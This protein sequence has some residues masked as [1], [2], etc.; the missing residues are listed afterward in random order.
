MKI[1]C[2]CVG[3]VVFGG[4][5]YVFGGLYGY[6]VVMLVECYD[7]RE[8]EWLIIIE[9]LYL[10]YGFCCVMIFVSKDLMVEV[11]FVKLKM[12]S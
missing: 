12:F 8:D 6:V 2:D 1:K 5:I 9:L 11:F 4:K 7:W 3:V 10:W